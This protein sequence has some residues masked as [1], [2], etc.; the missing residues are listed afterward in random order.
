MGNDPEPHMAT[1]MLN[2]HH[3]VLAHCLT[4]VAVQCETER[5]TGTV[6]G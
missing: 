6:S 1:I 4:F 5:R 2:R 3:G